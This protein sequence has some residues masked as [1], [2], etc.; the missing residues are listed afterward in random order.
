M[1][2]CKNNNQHYGKFFE[3]A[4]SSYINGVENYYND[5]DFPAEDIEFMKK[6]AE[7][8]AHYIHGNT[9]KWVG[10]HTI[11]EDCD[12]IVDN[13]RHIELKYVSSGNG[14]Y[15]N[16]SIYYFTKFGFNFKDYMNKA[17]LYEA[18]EQVGFTPNKKNNSPV[19]QK[20]SSEIRHNFS[21][22]YKKFII[23]AEELARNLFI[24]D[25]VDFLTNNPTYKYEFISDMLSKNSI[26]CTKT[27]PDEIIVYNYNTK[28]IFNIDLNSQIKTGNLNNTNKG[29]KIDDIRIA[30]GWQNGNGLNNPTLRVFLGA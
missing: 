17:G 20:V 22:E 25:V 27:V 16:T 3:S 5:F 13:K 9:C 7:K 14:T 1:N 26:T 18:I 6:D 28:K 11:S 4:V 8:C 29:I 2:I 24:S 12:I 15:F 10:N 19:N 23:P 30:I 21:S